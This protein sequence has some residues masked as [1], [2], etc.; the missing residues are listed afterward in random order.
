MR[1]RTAIEPVIGRGVRGINRASLGPEKEIDLQATE[2][3]S[4]RASLDDQPCIA[5]IEGH[6][7][8]KMR[9][10]HFNGLGY[11]IQ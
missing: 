10:G 8:M 5:S 11:D 6:V 4:V 3:P 7:N 9:S 2:I 1:S